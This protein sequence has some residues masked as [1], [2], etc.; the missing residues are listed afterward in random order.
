MELIVAL[1]LFACAV[2]VTVEAV[3]RLRR[4]P[5]RAEDKLPTAHAL[6][7]KVGEPRSIT[8]DQM[9][10]L[11]EAGLGQFDLQQ[12]SRQQASILLDA[13][14]Y[15]D[16]VWEQEFK[17]NR[18]ELPHAA[19]DEALTWILRHESFVERVVVFEEAPGHL[20]DEDVPK[21]TCYWHVASLL[22]NS[23]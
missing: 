23:T 13:V 9:A 16:D 19:R 8:E 11:R 20:N 7:P 17:R 18:A 4:R 22:R 21:D 12:L 5:A 15:L 1:A 6:L 14:K 2:A 3:R 10:P